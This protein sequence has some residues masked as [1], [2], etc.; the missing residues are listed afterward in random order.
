MLKLLPQDLLVE[1][2]KYFKY[3]DFAAYCENV[4]KS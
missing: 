3:F 4:E 1:L 2:G